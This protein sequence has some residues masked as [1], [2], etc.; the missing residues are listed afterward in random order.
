VS[1]E[2]CV[3]QGNLQEGLAQLQARVRAAPQSAPD[4]IFLFQLLSLLGQWERA[5]NQLAIAGELDA[6]LLL[7]V[8][9]YTA[10]L[11]SEATRA[12]VFRGDR[13]PVLI[14]APPEWVGPLLEALR[15]TS[16]G[17]HAHAEELRAEA[18]EA[19]PA[20][21]GT[22]NGVPFEW[23]ADADPRLGPCLEMVLEG[24]YCWVPLANVRQIRTEP[25][26]HL[27]DL[28]WTPAQ[29][30]FTNG[31]ASPVFIPTRYPGTESSTDDQCRLSRATEWLA[32]VEGVSLGIGQR[33]FATDNDDIGLCD[34]RTLVLG[35][36]DGDDVAAGESDG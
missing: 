8:N 2:E 1:P 19:A 5:K 28:V 15:L 12:A 22:A 21:G 32:P 13:P 35:A 24:R 10:A 36:T 33:L 4:R 11:E 16:L 9:G 18:F 34:L 17:H 26:A 6:S 3:K 27:R 29:I 25:P 31:G 7:T 23:I 30:Q 20:I 14:G